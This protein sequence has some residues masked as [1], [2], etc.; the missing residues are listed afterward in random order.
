M[1]NLDTNKEHMNDEVGR[2]CRKCKGR[3]FNQCLDCF[4][5]GMCID[6]Y[7]N[8]M[9]LPGDHKGPY[10]YE[11]CSIWYHGDPFNKYYRYKNMDN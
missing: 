7:G 10:N 11:N 6:K 9:C 8:S 3:T 1:L 4:N 5:C 2:F